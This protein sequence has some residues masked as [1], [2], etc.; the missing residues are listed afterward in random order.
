MKNAALIS[1]LFLFVNLLYSNGPDAAKQHENTSGTVIL[2]QE[3]FNDGDFTANPAWEINVVQMCAPR[4][5]LMQ[6]VDGA[7][8]IQ[9][10]DARTCGNW[11]QLIKSVNIPVSDST[12][13][14]F[15]VRPSYSSVDNGSGWRNEEFPISVRLRLLNRQNEYMNIWFCYN[16]RG[17]KTYLY[18]DNIRLVFPDCQKDK[19][20]RNEVFRIRDFFPDAKTIIG[21]S[22]VGSGWD[23][24]SYIDNIRIFDSK[25]SVSGQ[26]EKQTEEMVFDTD[27]L[28]RSKDEKAIRGYRENLRLAR[29]GNNFQ[30]QAKWLTYI[31]ETYYRSDRFDSAV[32]YLRQAVSACGKAKRGTSGRTCLIKPLTHLSKIYFLT[33]LYDSALNVLTDLSAIYAKKNDTAGIVSTLTEKAGIYMLTGENDNAEKCYRKALKTDQLTGNQAR[34]AKA[35]QNLGDLFLQEKKYDRA[36]ENY[37]QAL[38]LLKKTGDMNSAA[39][40]FFDMGNCNYLM[41]NY[42]EAIENLN[43]SLRIAEMRNLENLLSDIYLKFSE[44]YDEMGDKEVALRYYKM[45]YKVSKIILNKEKN[46][47]LADLFVKYE[48]QRKDQEISVLKKDNEIKKLMIKKNAYRFYLSI[49]VGIL[50]LILVVIIYARYRAKQK[51]NEILVEKNTLINRQKQE[52]EQKV[53]ERETMLRE[54]HHRVKNNLQTIYSMLEIQSRKLKDPEAKAVIRS[55]IDRVWAMALVHHKLYRDENLT[56]INISHYINDLT[57]NVLRTN[58]NIGRKISIKQEIGIKT[59][60]ADI[61]IPL[62]LIINELLTNAIKHA[63]GNA[64]HP[65]F[66]INIKNE[67]GNRFSMFVRDNGPGIPVEMITKHSETF[68]LELISLLVK[69]LKGTM[70]IFNDKGTCFKFKLKH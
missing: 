17:G 4:P 31:G 1:F 42:G 3:D 47:E 43:N 37:K 50:A 56:Q 35:Y 59:L 61:A 58:R 65:E 16:Y 21:I 29:L 22:V 27:T 8:H 70:E 53:K 46:R 55:N 11:A 13:I 5:A 23:Y 30:A 62:G 49:S 44:I 24:E 45:Y 48:T 19:W 18:K 32:V 36:R 63:W 60:E 9:Q 54:L 41:K 64:E 26:K 14:G 52:I 25:K 39:I 34:M 15:D 57:T 67:S 68:G 69:Q 10:K 12:R 40:L 2:F 33:G 28:A 6:V 20:I 51:A 38:T 66:V 7:L